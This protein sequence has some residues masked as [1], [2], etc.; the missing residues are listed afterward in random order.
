[1]RSLGGSSRGNAGK[2]SGKKP[3]GNASDA[4]RLFFNDPLSG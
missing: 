4:G 3:S 2:P 1:M